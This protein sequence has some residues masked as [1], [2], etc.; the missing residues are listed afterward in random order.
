MKPTDTHMKIKCNCACWCSIQ[1]PQGWEIWVCSIWS[2]LQTSGVCNI[3]RLLHI[4]KTFSVGRTEV[5]ITGF[6]RKSGALKQAQ[7]QESCG[8]A[9]P[10]ERKRAAQLT[11]GPSYS[12]NASLHW[13]FTQRWHTRVNQMC[14]WLTWH[15]WGM[16]LPWTNKARLKPRQCSE[17]GQQQTWV[18][19]ILLSPSSIKSTKYSLNISIYLNSS[20]EKPGCSCC[21]AAARSNLILVYKEVLEQQDCGFVLSYILFSALGCPSYDQSPVVTDLLLK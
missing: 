18:L 13:E 11:K 10:A 2:A 14:C 21:S 15:P 16:A 3:W 4:H 7:L 20:A 12:E 6:G 19:S 17:T 5:I 8:K 9:Q 1:D